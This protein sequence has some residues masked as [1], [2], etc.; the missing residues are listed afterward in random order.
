MSIV[1]GVLLVLRVCP[2]SQFMVMTQDDARCC[3]SGVD[4]LVLAFFSV[5]SVVSFSF[6][7]RVFWLLYCSP[8]IL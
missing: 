5:F 1:C 6:F 7:C 8:S 4:V 3:F 2:C